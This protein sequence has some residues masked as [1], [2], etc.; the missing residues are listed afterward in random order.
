MSLDIREVTSRDDG[1]WDE[2]ITAHP[3]G[4]I[5]HHSAWRK[6]LEST[7]GYHPLYLALEDS[8]SKELHGAYPSMLVRSRL[9]GDRLVTLPFTSYCAPL[10]PEG[11]VAEMVRYKLKKHPK[12]GYFELKC[13][14]PIA[15]APDFLVQDSSY[16]THTI[17]LSVGKSL[18][19]SAFHATSIRQR[20]RRAEKNGFRLRMAK[21]VEDLQSFY[22]LHL[23]VRKK[24]GL[25]PHPF[26]FF[27]NMWKE[28][29]P[30]NL[31]FVPL[32]EHDGKIVA[33]AF[34]L[35]FKGTFTYE[36]SATDESYLHLSCN[37]G[38]IWEV[39]K[40]ALSEGA[41]CFDFGR[42]ALDNPTLIE[43]K[44][45]WGSKRHP[46]FYYYYPKMGKVGAEGSLGRR[47]LNRANRLMPDALLEMEGNLLY[48]HLG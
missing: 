30:R 20:I 31:L 33:G 5:Y 4:T 10:A 26:K 28:L 18:L 40:I 16:V 45:R 34:T 14:D 48:R 8:R 39:L 13:K 47:I 29:F 6:V 3:A 37:Q 15:Q 12:I 9:T 41:K 36:Y 11:Y 19:F 1:R 35:K 22:R 46:L 32:L 7:Y 38:L 27:C 17:D 2:F 25:P 23:C 21:R 42:S 44:E 43:F 24:H